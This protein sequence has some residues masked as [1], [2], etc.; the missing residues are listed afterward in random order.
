MVPWPSLQAIVSN[1]VQDADTLPSLKAALELPDQKLYLQEDGTSAW[2]ATARP[3]KFLMGPSVL[4][5]PGF[6]SLVQNKGQTPVA[7][8]LLPLKPA[9]DEGLVMVAELKAF[10]AQDAGG[11]LMAEHAQVFLLCGGED[12]VV[13][14]P[15]GYYPC[16]VGC[17]DKDKPSHA[18]CMPV[19]SKHLAC[20]CAS[21]VWNPVSTLNLAVLQK[22]SSGNL[23]KNILDAATQLLHMRANV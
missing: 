9:I 10:L 2:L 23:W 15:Y 3:W 14:C 18:W 12:N 11:K 22:H 16:M 8:V 21:D 19:F 5:L 17:D 1:G 4:P 13:W 6:G 20:D 7:L